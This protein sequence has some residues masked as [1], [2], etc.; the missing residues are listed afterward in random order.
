M[1][2]FPIRATFHQFPVRPL[3]S[4][5]RPLQGILLDVTDPCG[6]H[7][8]LCK[9]R[10]HLGVFQCRW[11]LKVI[12]GEFQIVLRAFAARCLDPAELTVC[13][14][15]ECALPR[16]C[17]FCCM[18]ERVLRPCQK[19]CLGDGAFRD[20]AE[21]RLEDNHPDRLNV[22]QSVEHLDAAERIAHHLRIAL[23]TDLNPLAVLV[24]HDADG[25]AG[26]DERVGCAEAVRNEV[27]EV[28]PLL[29]R[30]HRILRLLAELRHKPHNELGIEFGT[31]F[32]LAVIGGQLL[33]R[34]AYSLAQSLAE[35]VL[36]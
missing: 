4:L 7:V 27:R 10:F 33:G 22:I 19:V 16:V 18:Y 6:E 30:H 34:I 14:R 25:L 17:Q 11:H 32:H 31:L 15:T 3:F 1:G 8:S 23:S 35:F 26:D 13:P 29:H 24:V 20:V 5:D 12:P 9:H 28:H 36:T 21:P 2:I